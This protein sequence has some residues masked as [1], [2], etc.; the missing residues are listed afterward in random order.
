MSVIKKFPK[1]TSF[2]ARKKWTLW[3]NF[4]DAVGFMHDLGGEKIDNH[5]RESS[6]RATY[7]L[8]ASIYKFLKCLCDFLE[9]GLLSQMVVASE[10]SL[11]ANKT[12][13]I[14][15]RA[16]LFSKLQINVRNFLHKK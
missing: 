3:D 16:Q 11:L 13:D 6:S 8:S 5:L 1:T 14:V 15:D 4:K 12:S 7:Y 2:I 10:F 9:N